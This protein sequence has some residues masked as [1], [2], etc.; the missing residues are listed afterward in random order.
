MDSLITAAARCPGGGGLVVTIGFAAL[1]SDWTADE[2]SK[3]HQAA[4]RPPRTFASVPKQ[5]IG[6]PYRASAPELGSSSEGP[7]G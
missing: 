2:I 3:A 4:Q 1:S 7:S 6:R 5:S